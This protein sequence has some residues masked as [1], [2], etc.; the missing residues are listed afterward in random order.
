MCG[1]VAIVLLCRGWR[2]VLEILFIR[3]GH[4]K[5]SH[6]FTLNKSEINDIIKAIATA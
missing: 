5:F 1:C 6:D 4:F 2:R 3:D